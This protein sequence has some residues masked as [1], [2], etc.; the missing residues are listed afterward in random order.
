[1]DFAR[2]LDRPLPAIKRADAGDQVAARDQ[3][4]LDERAHHARGIL[5]A[6]EG[7]ERQQHFGHGA[8]PGNPAIGPETTLPAPNDRAPEGMPAGAEAERP[9]GGSSPRP[10]LTPG[11]GLVGSR[12]RRPDRDRSTSRCSPS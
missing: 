10:A 7:R 8:S 11:R 9:G 12:R 6:L 3:P 1:H 4:L 2:V 5:L